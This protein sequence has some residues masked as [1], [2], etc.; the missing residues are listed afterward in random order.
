MKRVQL[1]EGPRWRAAERSPA[2][3]PHRRQAS[4]E[5]GCRVA[6]EA[7]VAQ[8]SYSQRMRRKLAAI[9]LKASVSS[10]SWRR[11]VSRRSQ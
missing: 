6:I 8:S 10:D 4:D 9:R 3:L 7:L 11:A 5:G 2:I 1:V